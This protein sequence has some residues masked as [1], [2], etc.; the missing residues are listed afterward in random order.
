MQEIQKYN[1]NFET[2]KYREDI[3]AQEIVTL[4]NFAKQKEQ[5]T[6][7][8]IDKEDFTDKN[9]DDQNEFLYE[10]L[11]NKFSYLSISYVKG[12]VSKIEFEKK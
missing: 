2:Y 11:E 6:Q 7:I 1:S 3:T 10:N 5:G 12:K 8:F 4:I 9:T